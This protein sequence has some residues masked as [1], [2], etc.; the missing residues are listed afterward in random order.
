MPPAAAAPRGVADEENS[1]LDRT[2][3]REVRRRSRR[4]LGGLLA[5]VRKTF[6]ITV[7]LVVLAQAAK[8]AGPALIAWAVDRG[9]PAA[10][11][12]SWG[13]AIGLA[14]AYV[15]SAMVAGGGTAGYIN[16]AATVSQAILLDLRQR[17]FR[18]TQRLSLEFHESYTSGRIISRQTADLE[19]LRELL[20]NG[21]TS[22]ASGLL[23]MTFT[24]IS[25]VLLDWRAGL[26]L[27]VAVIPDCWATAGSWTGPRGSSGTSGLAA[28]R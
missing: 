7:V 25:L 18:Q 22:L 19:A 20:D 23:F 8:V 13:P 9:L 17:V 24:G 1:Y 11:D 26:V 14:V 2:R 15:I 28:R 10:M 3:S 5:P 21:I 4:L 16:F 12:G 6:A 27:L